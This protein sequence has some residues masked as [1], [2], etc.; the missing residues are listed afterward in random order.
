MTISKAMS[1]CFKNSTKV[2][3][4]ISGRKH[5]IQVDINGKKKT[6]PK[7]LTASELNDALTKTYFFYANKF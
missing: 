6:Y 3:P 4:I 5:K 2:Y 7:E 1:I